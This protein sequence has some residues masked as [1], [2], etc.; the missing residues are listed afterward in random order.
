MPECV[1][2]FIEPPSKEELELRLRGRAT[3]SED[4]IIRRLNKAVHEISLKP[5]YNYTVINDDLAQAIEQLLA[6]INKHASGKEIP[7]R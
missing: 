4:Q 2:V 7:C 1:M 6:I 5:R 3:D